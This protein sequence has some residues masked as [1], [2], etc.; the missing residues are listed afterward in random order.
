[1]EKLSKEE[2]AKILDK[3]LTN[4]GVPQYGRATKIRKDMNASPATV[5]GW[6]QGSLP[7]DMPTALKF[8]KVYSM[9]PYLWVYGV[10][11]PEIEKVGKQSF[12]GLYIRK[13]EK[14]HNFELSD[15]QYKEVY[16]MLSVDWDA[17]KDFLHAMVSFL[18]K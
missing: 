7:Q 13:W 6:L 5:Q 15:T 11:N 12:I 2:R 1:M 3:V 9:C 17:A 10:P 4:N 8:C 16:S 18:K 14:E